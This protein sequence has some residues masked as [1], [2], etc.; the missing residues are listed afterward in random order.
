[1][2]IKIKD[3]KWFKATDWT[4]V[5]LFASQILGVSPDKLE[6]KQP[7]AFKRALVR[8]V[9]IK[10]H[11]YGVEFELNKPANPFGKVPRRRSSTTGGLT[12]EY[13]YVKSGLRA[14]EGDIRWDMDKCMQE[15]TTFE[16]AIAAW[17]QSHGRTRYKATGDKLEFDFKK[18]LNWALRRGWITNGLLS[19]D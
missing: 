1:M 18:Q 2:Q 10:T 12:G 14:P 6:G 13:T 7:E 4:T 19:E 17:E 15:H 3:E 8:Q 9:Y 16:S 5:K 11:E